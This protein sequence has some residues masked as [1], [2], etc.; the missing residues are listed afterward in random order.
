MHFLIRNS[1]NYILLHIY[2][3]FGTSIHYKYHVY[4]VDIFWRVI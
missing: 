3:N 2:R 1:F 4:A